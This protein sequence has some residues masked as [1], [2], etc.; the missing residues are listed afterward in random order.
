MGE[1]MT[2]T[3]VVAKVAGALTGELVGKVVPV[4]LVGTAAGEAV[5]WTIRNHKEIAEV[6]REAATWVGEGAPELVEY[7]AD[8]WDLTESVVFGF[9]AGYTRRHA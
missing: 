1:K 6:A 9:A 8:G 4:S 7:A 3:E 2:G 5:D